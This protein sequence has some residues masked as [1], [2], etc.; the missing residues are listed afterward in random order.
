MFSLMVSAT[1]HFAV[2]NFCNFFANFSFLLFMFFKPENKHIGTITY[3]WAKLTK[4]TSIRKT[5][6]EPTSATKFTFIFIADAVVIAVL[7]LQH[8]QQLPASPL[9]RFLHICGCSMQL[10]WLTRSQTSKFVAK[11]N[12]CCCL[13]HSRHSNE[14]RAMAQLAEFLKSATLSHSNVQAGASNPV[15]K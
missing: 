15:F 14:N 9:P 3:I 5:N 13:I 6:K 7:S 12:I 8:S 10:N 4:Q 11:S 1:I 2:D